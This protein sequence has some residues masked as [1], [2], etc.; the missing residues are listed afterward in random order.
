[1]GRYASITDI[2]DRLE[3]GTLNETDDPKLS[4]VDEW[5][6]EAEDTIDKRSFQRWDLHTVVDELV[7][8][9]YQT[10]TFSLKI[11]PIVKISSVYYQ[12]GDEWTNNWVLMDTDDYRITDANLSRI[13]TKEYFWMEDALKV[14]YVAGYEEIPSWLKSLTILEVQKIHIMSR[15]GISAADSE[16]ISVAVIRITDK[17]DK[18]LVFKLKGLDAEIE[19]RYSKLGKSNKSAVYNIGYSDVNNNNIRMRDY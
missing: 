16:N 19:E 1:M 8:P 13:R 10:N 14:T 9:K 11:R 12:T 7:S 5:I 4:V 15:L 3:L 2:Q 17:S 6:T 18:S